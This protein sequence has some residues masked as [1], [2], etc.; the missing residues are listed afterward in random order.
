MRELSFR[1]ARQRHGQLVLMLT[2]SPGTLELAR[3]KKG[4]VLPE[5]CHGSPA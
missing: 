1:R 4:Q 2:N 3:L 5:L